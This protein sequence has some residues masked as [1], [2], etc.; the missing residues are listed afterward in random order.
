MNP[1]IL[2]FQ[3]IA[4]AHQNCSR[5]FDD[6]ANVLDSL[7]VYPGFRDLVSPDDVKCLLKAIVDARIYIK[8][9]YRHN[10]QNHSKIKVRLS[11]CYC[12]LTFS[13]NRVIFWDTNS[14]FFSKN[15]SGT[16]H[17]LWSQRSLP[18]TVVSS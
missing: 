4:P 8:N 7:K 16:L 3:G 15:I 12:M 2:I 11:I 13:K 6:M 14:V 18:K 10:V 9:I 1:T 5:A 17:F